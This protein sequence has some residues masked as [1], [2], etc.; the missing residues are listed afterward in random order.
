MADLRFRRLGRDFVA[1]VE[2]VDL[3][4]DLRPGTIAELKKIWW[5]N[6]LLVFRNQDITPDRHVAFSRHFGTLLRHTVDEWL[7]PSQ[8]EILVLSNRGRGGVSPV[9]NGGAY[10]HSDVSYDAMPPIGSILHA[11]IVPPVGGHT[12]FADMYAAYAALEPDTKADLEHLSAVHN[13]RNRYMMMAANG[14]RP[15]PT[16]EKVAEW[17]NVE[18]P[19]VLV[20]PETNRKA[21]YVNEGFTIAIKGKSERQSAELLKRLFEHSVQDR[22][23]YE[24]SWQAGDVIMWDNR[25]TIH[26]AMPYDSSRYERTMQRTTIRAERDMAP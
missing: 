18:H 16:D 7:L 24:H 6:S 9:E 13:F 17:R 5:D 3:S 23:V 21:L 14:A 26:R 15:L 20:H 19:V 22:F 25:C 10:W 12:L 2:N 11:V 4:Q 1:E 8:P